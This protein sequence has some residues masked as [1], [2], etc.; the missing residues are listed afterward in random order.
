ML[1]EYHIFLGMCGCFIFIFIIVIT[2]QF[3]FDFF[4]SCQFS[5]V[6]VSIGG[7][8]FKRH[9]NKQPKNQPLQIYTKMKW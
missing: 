4:C 2:K 6:R 1:Y 8:F 3:I 7:V 9:K 5:R